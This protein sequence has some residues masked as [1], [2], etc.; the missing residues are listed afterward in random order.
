MAFIWKS[1]VLFIVGRI[2]STVLA[3]L[4]FCAFLIALS[5]IDDWKGDLRT[6][7]EMARTKQCQVNLSKQ[8]AEFIRT[9]SRVRQLSESAQTHDIMKFNPLFQKFI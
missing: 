8:V 4:A 7:D 1:T 2:F 6:L 9:H 5:F 3:P